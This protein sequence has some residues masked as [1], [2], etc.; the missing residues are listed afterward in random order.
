ML[1][2]NGVQGY[3]YF[4]SKHSSGTLDAADN[5]SVP[6]KP[7][8]IDV[9]NGCGTGG[10]G[11][12]MTDFCRAHGYDVVEMG[13]YKNFALMNTVIID[14]SGKPEQAR[15]LAMKAGVS[16]K[17]IV[18]QFSD[19]HLVTASIVIGKDYPTLLPWSK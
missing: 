11:S 6:S 14:R 17:N 15:L 8:Q 4:S 12:Q 7:V 3:Y 2:L 1:I 10:V 5:N 19:D 18:Q 13:N 16:P 9:L